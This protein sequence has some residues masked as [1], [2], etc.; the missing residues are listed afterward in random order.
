MEILDKTEA[1]IKESSDMIIKKFNLKNIEELS[2]ETMKKY[3]NSLIESLNDLE[4][5]PVESMN[6]LET[7]IN[8]IDEQ[9]Q[10]EYNSPNPNLKEIEEL[11][12]L[13]DNINSQINRAR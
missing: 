5:D 10:K 9:I 3:Y 4:L 8:D 13:R 2:N 6:N 12:K 11:E 1:I 7:I